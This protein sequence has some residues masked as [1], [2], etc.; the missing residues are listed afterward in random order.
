MKAPA[1]FCGKAR[2]SE[3]FLMLCFS[4]KER[5]PWYICTEPTKRSAMNTMINHVTIKSRHPIRGAA[6]L[7]SEKSMLLKVL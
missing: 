3:D 2:G 6:F 4:G 1:L 7:K 5:N